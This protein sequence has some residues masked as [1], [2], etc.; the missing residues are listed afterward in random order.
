[1]FNLYKTYKCT[2]LSCGISFFI[3]RACKYSA[4]LG[5]S[6]ISTMELFFAKIV[7]FQ[8]KLYRR[9]STGFYICLWLSSKYSSSKVKQW[10]EKSVFF[11]FTKWRVVSLR[12]RFSSCIK[13]FRWQIVKV[14]T[15]TVFFEKLRYN[16]IR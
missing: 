1:M 9:C 12:L 2:N 10:A 11:Y 3:W 8:K 16:D 6:R 15:A 4:Y 5:P 14:C 13:I 7:I